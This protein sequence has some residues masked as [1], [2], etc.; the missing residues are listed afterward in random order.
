MKTI[1]SVAVAALMLAACNP[2][3][4]PT[5]GAEASTVVGA[6]TLV[7]KPNL[8]PDVE[9]LPRLSGDSPA[10]ARINAVLDTLD[11]AAAENAASCAA[12]AGD[13]PGGGCGDDQR[14]G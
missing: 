3:A 12:D 6:V 5:K 4:P 7:E 1:T 11:A 13:G 2:G 10:I 14:A 9:A 8:S